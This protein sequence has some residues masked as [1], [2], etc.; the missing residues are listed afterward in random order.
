MI[1]YNS[2][3]VISPQVL[4]PNCPLLT[5]I[6]NDP[7]NVWANYFNRLSAELAEIKK[8]GLEYKLVAV[9][10]ALYQR[11][12][13]SDN[14]K[15][16]AEVLRWVLPPDDTNPDDLPIKTLITFNGNPVLV[17]DMPILFQPNA[18]QVISEHFLQYQRDLQTRVNGRL[19]CYKGR[20]LSG[21]ECI[22]PNCKAIKRMWNDV[23][24][25]FDFEPAREELK[26]LSMEDCFAMYVLF[27]CKYTFIGIGV[28]NRRQIFGGLL[29][30][31]RWQEQT[32]HAY[33]RDI[34]HQVFVD[35]V[36]IS[37]RTVVDFEWI[38]KE[39]ETTYAEKAH[40]TAEL[41]KRT[42]PELGDLIGEY[43]DI[44]D[45]VAIKQ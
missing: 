5:A 35:G 33:Y 37:I 1:A 11:I 17:K 13:A 18:N 10:A 12:T 44:N 22:T 29:N 3:P 34:K 19:V 45:L 4:L 42:L 21:P 28:D 20:A 24:S 7:N 36:C 6:W 2:I 8:A 38:D 39:N 26:M 41:G 43:F 25:T 16:L 30:E 9:F 14:L 32:G 27:Q 31:I 23:Y 15:K 40:I